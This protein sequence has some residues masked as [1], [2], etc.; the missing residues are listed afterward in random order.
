M[1]KHHFF[2]AVPGR[3]TRKF[4]IETLEA[5]QLLANNL[6]GIAVQADLAKVEFDESATD[7]RIVDSAKKLSLVKGATEHSVAPT[8]VVDLDAK[9]V[10]A[11]DESFAKGNVDFFVAHVPGSTLE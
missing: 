5:R 2:F 10:V 1:R 6:M 8:E 11:V 7:V 4:S 3:Q 9:M